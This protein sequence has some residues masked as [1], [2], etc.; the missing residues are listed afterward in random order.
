MTEVT[1]RKK[2]IVHIYAL[3]MTY[4]SCDQGSSGEMG[5]GYMGSHLIYA[6]F[7]IARDHVVFGG[8]EKLN[9]AIITQEIGSVLCH[10]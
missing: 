6:F 3:T 2:P 10:D 8:V 9:S 5:C 7:I 1:L 4:A